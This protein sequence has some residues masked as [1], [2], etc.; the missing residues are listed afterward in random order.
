MFEYLLFIIPILSYLV[1]TKYIWEPKPF[2]YFINRRIIRIGHRGAPL[3]AHENTL[4]SFIEAFK[5]G[6]DGIEL[7]AQYSFD[8]QVIVY[9]DWTLKL[10]N[11]RIKDVDKVSYSEI[12][13][14][15]FK[16]NPLYKIP[17]LIEVLEIVPKDYIIIIK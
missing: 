7:D 14:I 6:I 13:K 1:Y 5:H 12:E 4:Q 2:S 17:L 16:N 9:H 11:G 15:Y 8:K 3:L 10:L